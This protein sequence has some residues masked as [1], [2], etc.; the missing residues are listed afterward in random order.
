MIGATKD[1]FMAG[2]EAV[3]ALDCVE[4]AEETGENRLF[5][6]AAMLLACDAAHNA[7]M[8]AADVRS[9]EK[10]FVNLIVN[11]QQGSGK[12]QGTQNTTGC[13]VAIMTGV[14]KNTNRQVQLNVRVDGGGKN[15]PTTQDIYFHFWESS[16]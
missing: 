11:P 2:A 4:K 10:Q 7:A 14:N 1:A 15:N 8:A 12:W 9:D 13:D 6:F 16:P 5:V 3:L